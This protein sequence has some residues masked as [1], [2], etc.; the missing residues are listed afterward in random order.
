MV[1]KYSDQ[2][3]LMQRYQSSASGRQA[4]Q[5][6]ADKALKHANILCENIQADAIAGRPSAMRDLFYWYGFDLMG[7]FVINKPFGMLR[8]KEWQHI[9][10]R[11][12]HALSLL[13][14]A[15]PA[16]WLVQLA[17]H[18]GP[19]IYQVRSWNLM[20]PVV[21]GCNQFTAPR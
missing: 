8:D 17:F 1:P 16:P 15:T 18:L 3:T 4:L 20:G 14:P 13:G 12:Q 2:L 21:L 11:L 7:D 9:V 6:H 19:K 5:S 10:V